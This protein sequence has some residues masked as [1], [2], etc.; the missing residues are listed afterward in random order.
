MGWGRIFFLGSANLPCAV[1]AANDQSLR[2]RAGAQAQAQ[3]QARRRDRRA[4]R[5]SPA[6]G[7]RC[8]F[9]IVQGVGEYDYVPEP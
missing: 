2:R 4:C 7:G 8:R 6:D 9:V 1:G 3:A 5:R